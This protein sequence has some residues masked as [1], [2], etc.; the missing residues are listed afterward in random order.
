M[1]RRSHEDE[2]VRVRNRQRLPGF[3]VLVGALQLCS[4]FVQQPATDER[5]GPGDEV[6]P[7]GVLDLE[8]PGDLFCPLARDEEIGHSVGLRRQ[9]GQ[10][11]ENLLFVQ[12][13]R[14]TGQSGCAFAEPELPDSRMRAVQRPLRPASCA[15]S[16]SFIYPL[17][18][19]VPIASCLT[20][21]SV[22]SVGAMRDVCQFLT[23]GC[24]NRRAG[25]M[26]S[27]HRGTGRA[28][29][30]FTRSD[31]ASRQGR[32]AGAVP[33]RP[34]RLIY[35]LRPAGGRRVACR[36]ADSTALAKAAKISRSPT[37]PL[38]NSSHD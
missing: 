10:I 34:G 5:A 24:H 25:R 16:L 19:W 2:L 32:V 37:R 7:R 31:S 26:V 18:P 28:R 13:W 9:Q 38:P 15:K 1:E 11:V 21:L 20:C 35:C 30:V 6:P 12:A 17:F 8:S 23:S 4:L 29:H 33:T 27:G 22:L 36:R 3:L 14:R